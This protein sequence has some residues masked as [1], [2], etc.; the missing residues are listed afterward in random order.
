L[1]ID[2]VEESDATMLPFSRDGSDE[3]KLNI[4][5]MQGMWY[6]DATGNSYLRQD[7]LRLALKNFNHIERHFDQIVE[8]QYDFHMYSMRKW[9]LSAYINMIDFADNVIHNKYACRSAIG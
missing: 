2:K 4:H 7:N 6:E 3:S 1:K 8:D 5:D 9:T